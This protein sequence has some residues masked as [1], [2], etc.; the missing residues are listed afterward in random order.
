M[1][2]NT[3]RI[4]LAF[5]WDERA[6]SQDITLAQAYSE[7]Y[8]YDPAG[9]MSQLRHTATAGG[10]TRTFILIPG[11]NR[12]HEVSIGRNSPFRY[13]YDDNGNLI[14]EGTARHFEWDHSDRMKIFRTQPGDSEPSI[15]AQYLYDASGQRVKKLVRRQGGGVETTVYVD[16]IFEHQRLGQYARPAQQPSARDGRSAAG[17][18]GADWG[19]PP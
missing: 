10:F 19:R 13:D 15:Y 9:N 18:D 3:P 6:K 1:D 11:T 2:E 12:L 5:P 16:G 4:P 17:G 8:A 7:T 14:R